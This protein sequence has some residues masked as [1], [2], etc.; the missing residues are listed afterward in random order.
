MFRENLTENVIFEQ[1]LKE[2]RKKVETY[3]F[4]GRAFQKKKI[5]IP[6]ALKGARCLHHQD[7]INELVFLECVD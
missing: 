1:Q 2:V 7:M 4:K 3:D 5:T 6:K